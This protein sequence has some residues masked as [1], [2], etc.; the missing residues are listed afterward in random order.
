MSL[1]LFQRPRQSGSVRLVCYPGR[2][3]VTGM[4]PIMLAGLARFLPAFINEVA[5]LDTEEYVRRCLPH[6]VMVE[7]A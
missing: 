6:L 4:L 7:K 5:G 3:G 1:V 2:Q